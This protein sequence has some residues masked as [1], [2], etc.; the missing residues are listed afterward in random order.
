MAKKLAAIQFEVE[1]VM[2][3]LPVIFFKEGN[4]VVAYSPAIDLSTCGA[5]EEQ[6]RERF[7]E[8]SEI[9]F[10][11]II[12]M[13]TL[14]EVLTECGWKKKRVNN[15]NGWFPPVYKHELMPIPE[16]VC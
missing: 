16:G 7:A 10:K 9:F 4:K 13:G 2:G 12:K 15:K 5:T 3:E 14:E 8:A 1:K 6:A 11:E